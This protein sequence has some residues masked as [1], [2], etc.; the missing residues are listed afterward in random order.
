MAGVV[1]LTNGVNDIAVHG[2]LFFYYYSRTIR[3]SNIGLQSMIPDRFMLLS[4]K[5][6]IADFRGGDEISKPILG[7]RRRQCK[8]KG[9]TNLVR[10]NLQAVIFP[11]LTYTVVC[12]LNNRWEIYLRT[13]TSRIC[14]IEDKSYFCWYVLISVSIFKLT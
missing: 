11:L 4:P 2:D 7:N 5:C 13:A 12:S 14:L 6:N 10:T 8:H 1:N 3:Y 9:W